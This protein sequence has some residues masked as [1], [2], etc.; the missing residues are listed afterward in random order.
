MPLLIAV[1]VFLVVTVAFFA[2]ISLFD[3]RKAQ[4][5]ILRD[6]LAATQEPAEQ[7]TPDAAFVRDE[8]LS[9]IP[10]FDTWLRRS[11][12]VSLLQK[13]LAQGDVDV[14]AGNFLFFCAISALAFAAVVIFASGNVLFG[15]VG[16]LLGFFLPY[17]YASHRRNKRFQKFEEKFPEAIDTLARAV[18]AGHAFTTA[19]EMIANE[20]SEPVAGEFRQL[21]EEQKFGLPVRDALLNLADRIPLVDVKFFV[22]AVM[23]QRETGGN[24]AEILDNLSYVI[25][26]RFKILRQVRVHTAQGRLTM[27]LLMALP[28][29]VVVTMQVLNPGFIRPL[30]IDPVGHA[31]IVG[32]ITLQT[33]GYFVIRRI[34]RIQ[35]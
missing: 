31:L 23:L 15:W 12:R 8:V 32:G 5:R 28:P 10:A 20:V 33:L 18:R 17:A 19:L 21:Y 34:I 4:A 2:G 24:L 13:M 3:Q 25:R 7:T 6:R 1:L 29:A 16:A 35:V 26:E 27:M 30:F 11:E 9:Q 22:T 14:R